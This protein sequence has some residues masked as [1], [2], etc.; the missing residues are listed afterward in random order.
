MHENSDVSEEE[1]STCCSFWKSSPSCSSNQCSSPPPSVLVLCFL[2]D[3]LPSISSSCWSASPS[4]PLSSSLRSCLRAK[5]D[6][7]PKC[8]YQ[9]GLSESALRRSENNKYRL[10]KK[11]KQKIKARKYEPIRNNK[12]RAFRSSSVCLCVCVCLSQCKS[13]TSFI[14]LV[15]ADNVISAT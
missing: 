4:L 9:T 15:K 7:F 6:L 11:Q 1:D 8:F 5:S 14:I 2:L 3:S 12:I 13:F 10:K